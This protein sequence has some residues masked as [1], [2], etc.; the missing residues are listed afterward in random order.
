MAIP[1]ITFYFQDY[2]PLKVSIKKFNEILGHCLYGQFNLEFYSE[3]PIIQFLH[4]LFRVSS[5]E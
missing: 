3:L 1:F 5:M 2:A 4:G